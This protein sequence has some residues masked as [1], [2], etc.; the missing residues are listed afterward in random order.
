MQVHFD[1]RFPHE[2]ACRD[3]LV[4]QRWPK[5]YRCPR[6]PKARVHYKPSTRTFQCYSC[7]RQS[8]ITAGTIFHK[9][10]IPLRTWFG[11]IFLMA[12][13]PHG[14]S[15]QTLQRRLKIKSYRT[16]WSLGHKVR[17]VMLQWARRKKSIRKVLNKEIE[18]SRRF[19]TFNQLQ[20]TFLEDLPPGRIPAL[21]TPADAHRPPFS[22][23]GF[24][25]KYHRSYLAE[26]AYH[27]GQ[28]DRREELFE[29]LLRLCVYSPKVTLRQIKA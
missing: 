25:P 15:A 11:A 19:V 18:E 27:H 23:H 29:H 9:S 24:L 4:R 8:S 16:A 20:A 17:Q 10:R 26:A 5:G 28:N 1:R 14:L 2:S 12:T 13:T 7:D 3:F 6:C 22:Y 21:E